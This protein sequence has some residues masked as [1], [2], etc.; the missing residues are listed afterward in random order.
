MF[1]IKQTKIILLIYHSTYY[2]SLSYVCTI[3]T[4]LGR[5]YRVPSSN[6]SPQ[7]PRSFRTQFIH[8]FPINLG[9]ILTFFI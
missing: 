7:L 2:V 5:R 3:C 1:I 8:S 4:Q 9:H 6:L